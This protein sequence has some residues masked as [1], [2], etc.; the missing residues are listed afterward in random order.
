MAPS[1]DMTL[2][3]A[4]NMV[5]MQARIGFSRSQM[6]KQA[7]SNGMT[8][9]MV[10]GGLGLGAG[11]LSSAMSHNPQKRWGRNA[12]LG[13][14]LGAGVGGATGLGSDMVSDFT[15]PTPGDE[16]LTRLQKAQEN[17]PETTPGSAWMNFLSSVPSR[18]SNA[19]GF[20]K[21][22]EEEFQ[23]N[24]MNPMGHADLAPNRAAAADLAK[25]YTSQPGNVAASGAA[26]FGVGHLADMARARYSPVA[27]Q[28][29]EQLTPDQLAKMPKAVG[30][31][32][33]DFQSKALKPNT[34]VTDAPRNLFGFAKEG[35]TLT[36]TKPLAPGQ[37]GPQLPPDTHTV[38]LNQW[39]KYQT[40]ANRVGPRKWGGKVIGGIGGTVAA[41][42]SAGLLHGLMNR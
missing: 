11:L 19:S 25:Q 31:G 37:F 4:A 8:G 24:H 41:P 16:M 13:T 14:L 23:A 33:E 17:R 18:L 3:D 10:G 28:T 12:L 27:S 42:F 7:M 22:T 26:G 1:F 39:N 32:I 38:P 29:I 40:Q 6:Q 2:E 35:P 36:T 5:A 20:D 21:A 30:T 34:T 9:A 15:K